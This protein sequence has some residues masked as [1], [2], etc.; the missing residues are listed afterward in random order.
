MSLLPA[1]LLAAALEQPR[2]LSFSTEAVGARL[3]LTVQATGDLGEVAVRRE[4]EELVLTF[5][6]EAPVDLAPPPAAAPIESVRIARQAG[7][8]TLR[9][10]VA[11]EVPYEVQ[12]IGARVTVLFGEAP[13]AGQ[14]PPPPP[15]LTE[16]Y[17]KIL[18][19]P[20]AEEPEGGQVVQ[21]AE[22]EAPEEDRQREG[23]GIGALRLRPSTSFSYVD[24]ETSLLETP[25][26]VRDR[27][28]QV[29]PKVEVEL[30]I[31]S[32][33][34]RVDYQTHLRRLSS[35]SIVE[36]A[37]HVANASF[38]TP[39]GGALTL[40]VG[41]H[42]ARGTLESNEVDPG[43]EFFFRLGRFVRNEFDVGVRVETAGRFGLDLGGA[44]NRVRFSEPAG[45][46][47]YD[48]RSARAGLD[49]DLGPEARAVLSYVF[50]RT[51]PPDERP[52][53]ES[54]AHSVQLAVKGEILPLLTG[55]VSVGY[56]D[57]HSPRAAEGGR[58][59]R[60]A[61]LSASLRKQLSRAS[62]LT[63]SAHRS[64]Q[65]SAFE[66]NAFYVS[67]S[68]EAEVTLPLPLSF[69]LKGGAGYYWNRY[70]TRAS[71][72]GEPREDGIFGWSIGLGRPVSRWAFLRADYRRERRDSNLDAFDNTTR[73][74]IVQ[75]GIGLFGA[76][77]R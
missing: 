76:P 65:L 47:G 16:L 27:Y 55:E 74:L 29:S 8:L 11:P 35:F 33:D 26:P 19:V 50:D 45:F 34:L 54:R 77:A 28:L 49:Y 67:T 46:F 40:D 75:L 51:P 13:G 39:L 25:Q 59:F 62:S 38:K 64:T 61:V 60:G 58:R 15:D 4:A 57:Q 31:G 2:I 66:Q 14:E 12:R 6:A 21:T 5:A 44:F 48:S 10:H 71:G 7:T 23:F 18:P 24:A 42:Y 72:L 56:R 1:L 20:P 63:L 32:G 36:R 68:T 69:A 52:E 3:A 22:S 41:D 73:A 53:A 30:P 9:V 17:K 37:S 70:R 43:R